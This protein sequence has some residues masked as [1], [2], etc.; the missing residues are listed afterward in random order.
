MMVK[1]LVEKV[2]EYGSTLSIISRDVRGLQVRYASAG[3]PV[4]SM[5]VD[6]A[7]ASTSQCLPA[8]GRSDAAKPKPKGHTAGISTASELLSTS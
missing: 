8:V 3:L 7:D 2:D 5:I 6:T 1:K 4:P